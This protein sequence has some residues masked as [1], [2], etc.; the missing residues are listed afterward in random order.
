MPRRE[1]QC[2]A[3]S[4]VRDVATAS[5]HLTRK[6][7][8]TAP[9]GPCRDA[10]RPSFPLPP[11]RDRSATT[12]PTTT[13]TAEAAIRANDSSLATAD[14]RPR[15]ADQSAEG[16]DGFGRRGRPPEAVRKALLGESEQGGATFQGRVPSRPTY[17]LL[18]EAETEIEGLRQQVSSFEFHG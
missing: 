6:P 17:D 18:R 8:K 3:G 1:M 2:Q 13:A 10:P 12:T 9:L 11:A 5:R 4:F 16:C 7:A 14:C 15:A